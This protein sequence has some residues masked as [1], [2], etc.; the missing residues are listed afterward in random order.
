MFCNNIQ[1]CRRGSDEGPEVCGDGM[2]TGIFGTLRSL[3]SRILLTLP[4]FLPFCKFCKYKAQNL[5]RLQFIGL[6][7]RHLVAD[8]MNFGIVH[9]ENSLSGGSIRVGSDDLRWHPTRI[10]RSRDFWSRNRNCDRVFIYLL[11]CLLVSI[12]SVFE[13]YIPG[14]SKN[15]VSFVPSTSYRPQCY[16]CYVVK[17]VK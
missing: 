1:N 14:I 16:I 17:S 8:M 7:W 2:T 6:A 9:F 3:N 13:K 15:E 11:N 12:N 4:T 10:S 5:R